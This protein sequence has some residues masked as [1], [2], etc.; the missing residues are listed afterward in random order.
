MPETVELDR[1]TG[2]I[3]IRS[4]GDTNLAT[5]KRSVEESLEISR[6]ER[7]NKVLVDA[8]DLRALPSVLD[9]FRFASELPVDLKFAVVDPKHLEDKAM[10]VQS[11]AQNRSRRFRAFRR[12][13]DAVNWLKEVE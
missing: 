13:E 10:F 9:L 2:F 12:F 4:F 5:M 1:D 11:V 8:T 6:R 3:R 7:V